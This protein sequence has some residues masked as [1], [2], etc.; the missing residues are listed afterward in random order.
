MKFLHNWWASIGDVDYS[1]LYYH[2]LRK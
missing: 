2:N 1:G